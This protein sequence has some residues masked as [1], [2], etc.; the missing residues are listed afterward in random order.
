[1]GTL[2]NHVLRGQIG[3]AKLDEGAQ[4]MINLVR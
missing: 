2:L 1:M 4:S 3:C